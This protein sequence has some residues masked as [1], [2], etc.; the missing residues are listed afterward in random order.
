MKKQYYFM[1]ILT[2]FSAT[3]KIHAQSNAIPGFRFE[4]D[5]TVQI[6][7][8][9]ALNS[10]VEFAVYDN[11]K[12]IVH[13]G[14]SVGYR[15]N[16]VIEFYLKKSDKQFLSASESAHRAAEFVE[17]LTRDQ[18]K[19]KIVRTFIADEPLVKKDGVV[20]GKWLYHFLIINDDGSRRLI[21]SLMKF[22][23]VVKIDCPELSQKILSKQSGYTLDS[24]GD[25]DK[26]L[27]IYK[28]ISSEFQ[29]CKP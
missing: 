4:E 9:Y 6:R 18:K 5:A 28:K 3:N 23:D 26:E 11:G 13:N 29:Q 24:S 25:S 27:E 7:K 8:D 2:L 10:K 14:R 17:D 12:I 22:A 19:L 1:L 15:A 16:D 21:P 20:N